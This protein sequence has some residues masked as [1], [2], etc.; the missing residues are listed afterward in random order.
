MRKTNYMQ[1]NKTKLTFVQEFLQNVL[2]IALGLDSLVQG[3]APRLD[4]LQQFFVCG[5][6]PELSFVANISKTANRIH[7]STLVILGQLGGTG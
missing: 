1:Q 3:E 2:A 4:G 7:C 5:S 6:A